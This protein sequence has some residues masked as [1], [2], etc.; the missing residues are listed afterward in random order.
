[1]IRIEKSRTIIFGINGPNAQ[2]HA[3]VG[4]RGPCRP[5][6]LRYAL[7][8]IVKPQTLL[9]NLDPNALICEATALSAWD[10]GAVDKEGKETELT[11]RI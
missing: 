3:G 7:G 10:M 8:E 9:Q 1:M 2:Q 6:A 11:P 5:T 4:R